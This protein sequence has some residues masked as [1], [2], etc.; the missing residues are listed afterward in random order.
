MVATL[1]CMAVGAHCA[2]ADRISSK[3]SITNIGIPE[4]LS[5]NTVRDIEQDNDGFMWF[6][7]F[8]GLN[9]YDGKNFVVHKPKDRP[10]GLTDRQLRSVRKDDVGNLWIRTYDKSYSCYN[11]AKDVYYPLRDRYNRVC[12]FAQSSLQIQDSAVL[13][14]GNAKG[15][16]LYDVRGVEPKCIWQ[17]TLLY[18]DGLR[19][20][21]AFWLCGKDVVRLSSEGTEERLEIDGLKSSF[22]FCVQADIGLIVDGT[23]MLRRFDAR[24]LRQLPDVMI[25][26]AGKKVKGIKPV[27]KSMVIMNGMKDGLLLYDVRQDEM[28]PLSTIGAE[29]IEGVEVEILRD[30]AGNCWFYDGKGTLYYLDEQNNELQKVSILDDGTAN[31]VDNPRI[32]ILKDKYDEGVFWI[33]SYGGGLI[34]YDSV[35]KTKEKITSK[36]AV[37]PNYLLSIE[38]DV[39]GNIWVGSEFVGLL[40]ITPQK[41][42]SRIIRPS[43]DGF[44]A[45]NNVKTIY[46]DRDGNIWI[47][48]RNGDLCV[49][50]PQIK[51]IKH[52]IKGVKPYTFIEDKDGHVWMGTRG[53]GIY[54]YDQQTVQEIAHYTHEKGNDNTLSSNDVFKIIKD[55]EENI[56]IATFGG[57]IDYVSASQRKDVKFRRF[58]LG[59]TKRRNQIRDILQDSEGMIWAATADGIAVFN[60][61]NIVNDPNDFYIYGYNSGD[62]NGLESKDIR[63]I[64]EDKSGI[65]WIGTGGG[66]LYRVNFE[67][68]QVKFKKYSKENGL[69]SDIVSSIYS[70]NDS[71]LWVGT[72]CGMAYFNTKR[73]TIV[74]VQIEE[75][76]RGTLYN[77]HA[78]ILQKGTNHLLWGTLDGILDI[79]VR[80]NV[81]TTERSPMITSLTIDGRRITLADYADITDGESL[82]HTTKI[83][84]PAR[85]ST[86][87]IQLTTLDMN[88]LVDDEIQYKMEGVDE[89]TNM[90]LTDKVTYNNLPAGEYTFLMKTNSQEERKARSV[91]IVIS[92]QW[93][94]STIMRILYGLLFLT[95]TML[96]MYVSQKY[97]KK[98]ASEKME[99]SLRKYKSR[100]FHN[101]SDQLRLPIN[102][103]KHSSNYLT[104]K[105]M[106]MPTGIRTHVDIIQRNTTQLNEVLSSLLLFK[107]AK[108]KLPLNIEQVDVTSYITEIVH[109][110]NEISKKKNIKY[111]LDVQGNQQIAIDKTRVEMIL[112]CLLDNAFKYTPEG[113]SVHI[114]ISKNESGMCAISVRDS[115]IGINQDNIETIFNDVFDTENVSTNNINLSAANDLALSHHGTLEYEE[116][117]MGGSIF[118]LWLPTDYRQYFDVNIIDE[119]SDMY[120]DKEIV[121]KSSKKL[122]RKSNDSALKLRTTILLLEPDKDLCHFYADRLSP[123]FEVEIAHDTKEAD[124]LVEKNRP[125]IIACGHGDGTLDSIKYI[126]EI[127]RL[128][129]YGMGKTILV[130]KDKERTEETYKNPNTMCADV[131]LQKPIVAEQLLDMIKKLARQV[132]QIG[133]HLE[134]LHRTHDNLEKTDAT[135]WSKF[136]DILTKNIGRKNFSIDDIGI[137]LQMRNREIDEKV[138]NITGLPTEEYVELW[139][140]EQCRKLIQTGS[141][142]LKQV[143]SVYSVGDINSFCRYYRRLFGI[144]P[145]DEKTN[146]DINQN[147]I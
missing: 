24:T 82:H 57:S 16:Y 40:K 105:M 6:A 124:M 106:Q 137:S 15:A 56:W 44:N 91:D 103:I 13:I 46:E 88:A 50:D 133:G 107:Q 23:R 129:S 130:T 11:P 47:G 89:W 38:Q 59:N 139:K 54:V 32:C 29:E 141:R 147:N 95:L 8:D 37:M 80:S 98:I 102:T 42:V 115:G 78:V 99:E 114:D 33:T 85:T 131:I 70:P 132:D 55:R 143:F 100:F 27:G 7:T 34:Y 45:Q 28:L 77:D 43:V 22:G 3:L 20:G 14:H 128:F 111:T 76:L 49:Y 62:I 4:G 120:D 96:P 94:D 19:Y 68:G 61:D 72:E 113:G 21:G 145:F 1:L 101:I 110:Y 121:E 5:Q 144:L 81:K 63:T 58:W 93:S 30:N 74:R 136:T 9:R 25:P 51:E 140:M 31:I 10:N 97:W 52:R 39:D 119:D 53:S 116:N 123:Y 122:F 60:P 36:N 48:I 87:T 86:F 79:D 146:T 90:Q 108:E 18:R 118:T 104:N 26:V 127:R 117:P 17:D 84:I 35:D 65:V 135:F 92:S 67:V 12:E 142:S 64:Y 134:A 71:I 69:P 138:R 73:E 109:R 2:N 112:K 41:F 126:N 125:E 75:N 83:N 66:G